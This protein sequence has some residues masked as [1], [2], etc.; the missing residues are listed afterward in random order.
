MTFLNVFDQFDTVTVRQ[1]HVSQAKIK[2]F[3][4]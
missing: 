1:A 2:V 4:R 3:T